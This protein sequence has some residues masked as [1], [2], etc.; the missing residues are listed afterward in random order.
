MSKKRS[1]KPAARHARKDERL[2]ARSDSVAG[3]DVQ[4]AQAGDTAAVPA[5]AAATGRS[6]DKEAATSASVIIISPRRRENRQLLTSFE[7]L[8]D[9]ERRSL[10][11]VAGVP[12]QI[13]APG[14]WRGIGFR[15]GERQFVSS[16]NEVNEILTMPAAL[17]PVPATRNW[18]LGVANVRGNLI[19]VVDLKQFLLDQRT[20]V[21]ERSRVLWVKQSGGGVGLLVDE[22]LGQ[23]NLTDEQRV[24]AEGESDERLA[25]FVTENVASGTVSLGMFSMVELTRAADFQQTSV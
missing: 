8:V 5:N 16:I 3:A 14:L 6:D 2:A 10:A 20:H 18:L 11:H 12:E 25:R 7:A 13:E 4:S 15:V 23:R 1:K 22:V 9:Y 19:A 17:T 21:N 24:D